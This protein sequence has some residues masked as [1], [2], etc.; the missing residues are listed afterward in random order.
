MEYHDLFYESQFLGPI[1]IPIIPETRHELVR[2]GRS[3]FINIILQFHLL[4]IINFCCCFVCGKRHS[5]L[6][7][8]I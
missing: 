4:Y 3:V 5:Q 7:K 6:L 2:S 8:A 1:Q